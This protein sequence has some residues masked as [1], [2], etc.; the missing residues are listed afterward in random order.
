MMYHYT[1]KT[2]FNGIGS[3]VVW[4]F[5]AHRQRGKHPHGAYFT[6]LTRT[7]A[8]L[9][10]K[11]RVPTSKVQYVFEF[12]DAGDLSPLPGGRGA[13]VFYSANDYDVDKPRQQYKGVV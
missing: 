9:A 4:T 5:K 7:T 1:N 11:L 6:T 8:N 13:H 10:L 12:T 2:G 3:Q